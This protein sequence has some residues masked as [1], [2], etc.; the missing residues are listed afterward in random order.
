MVKSNS[1]IG[2]EDYQENQFCAKSHVYKKNLFFSPSTD[3]DGNVCHGSHL[4]N[5]TL[6]MHR[7]LL[8]SKELL[9]KL[10]NLYPF[11]STIW[12]F[13]LFYLFSTWTTWINM[14]CTLVCIPNQ[15][16]LNPQWQRKKSKRG[17]KT[18]RRTRV[19]RKPFSG[20]NQTITS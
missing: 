5:I 11:H 16:R 17:K 2:P 7:L 6:T 13:L 19:K 14:T 8:S 10:I 20:W 3:D 12:I 18:F 9:D 15:A 4:L 1:C